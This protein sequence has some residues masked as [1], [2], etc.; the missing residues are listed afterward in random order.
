MNLIQT[1]ISV[2]F[3]MAFLTLAFLAMWYIAL[4]LLL[5]GV[6]V[7]IVKLLRLQ[8]LAYQATRQANGCHIREIQPEQR[9]RHRQNVIDVDYTELP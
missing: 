7:W 2:V 5:L 9:R 3:I 4:P 8:W 1:F 6:V